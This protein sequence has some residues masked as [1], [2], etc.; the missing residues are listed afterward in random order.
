M[1]TSDIC[2][3]AAVE[4]TVHSMDEGIET[5]NRT[6][7]FERIGGCSGS[8]TGHTSFP[9]NPRLYLRIEI[10]RLIYVHLHVSHTVACLYSS[11]KSSLSGGS[12]VAGLMELKDRCHSDMWSICCSGQ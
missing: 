7:L 2:Y 1:N 6:W 4:C 10:H 5:H 11:Y 8:K 3:Y 9:F 12:S